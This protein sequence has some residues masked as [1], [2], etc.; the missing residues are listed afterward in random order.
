MLETREIVKSPGEFV[1]FESNQ[2]LMDDDILW[3]K[4]KTENYPIPR[5]FD[6]VWFDDSETIENIEPIPDEDIK[7]DLEKQMKKSTKNEL[8]KSAQ[9]K[10]N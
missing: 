2:R 4:I 7:S 8:D 3:E 5:D 6:F 1:W 10:T 9:S